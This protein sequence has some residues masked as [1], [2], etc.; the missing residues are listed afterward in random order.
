VQPPG[1]EGFIRASSPCL[2]IGYLGQA[3]RTRGSAFV[4]TD[5]GVTDVYGN[6]SITGRDSE[7]MNFRGNRVSVV[8]VE[9][10]MMQMTGVLDARLKPY[11]RDED[12]QCTLRVVAQTDAHHGELR[13]EII[14]TVTPKGLIREITF[15][16][17]LEKTRSGKP[18]RRE[19]TSS[20]YILEGNSA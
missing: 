11:S 18:I 17:A 1:S 2:M 20:T 5:L 6:L 16:E 8:S 13:R 9:A 14:R 19:A 12:T 10:T 7:V 4:T 3:P 15:V